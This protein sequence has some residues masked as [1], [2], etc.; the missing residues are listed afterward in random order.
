[1]AQWDFSGLPVTRP[2]FE[3]ALGST[4]FACFF[5]VKSIFSR[6]ASPRESVIVCRNFSIFHCFYQSASQLGVI[7]MGWVFCFRLKPA[8]LRAYLGIAH[9]IS[10]VCT[11]FGSARHNDSRLRIRTCSLGSW[12]IWKCWDMVWTVF[13]PTFP[14]AS[15]RSN[16]N[17]STWYSWSEWW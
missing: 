17:Y 12:Y 8:C 3:S 2:G 4:F 5:T 16:C 1:M 11:S 7:Y 9:S 10:S 15:R 14:R 13:Y 6:K